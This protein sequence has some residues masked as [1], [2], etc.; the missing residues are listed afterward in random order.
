M[1]RA[2]ESTVRRR[3]FSKPQRVLRDTARHEVFNRFAVNCRQ[4]GYF[5]L[6]VFA[7]TISLFFHRVDRIKV[8]ASLHDKNTAPLCSV[9]SIFRRCRLFQFSQLSHIEHQDLRKNCAEF[10][11]RE[12]PGVRYGRAGELKETT[13]AE[14]IDGTE[15]GRCIFVCRLAMTLMRSTRR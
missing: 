9:P 14:K 12:C 1:N 11:S 3:D 15:Q 4:H 10:A 2:L 5:S 7:P 13:S 6:Q 8:I